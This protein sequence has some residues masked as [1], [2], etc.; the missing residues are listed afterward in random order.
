M[1]T[2]WR[3]PITKRGAVAGLLLGVVVA[4]A[5]VSS[6]GLHGDSSVRQPAVSAH[7]TADVAAGREAAPDGHWMDL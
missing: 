7:R 6:P 5:P 1:G 4:T 2:F 3:A